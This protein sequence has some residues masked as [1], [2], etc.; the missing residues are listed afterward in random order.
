MTLNERLLRAKRALFDK[1]Y[2]FLNDRQREA[3]F[4]AQGPLLV[5]AGAGSGKTTVLVRR[6]DYLVRYGNAYYSTETPERMLFEPYIEKLESLAQM[7]E[8]SGE[9][10]DSALATFAVN[11]V[12]PYQILA[13]TFT[14]KAAGEIKERLEKAL[15]EQ[16]LDIWAGTFH[17]VCAKLLRMYIDRLGFEKSFTIYDTDDQKRLMTAILKEFEVSD[18]S[19]PPKTVLNEISRA[20]E[21]LLL[22]EDYEATISTHDLRRRTILRLYKEY[23]KRKHIA[24][25]LDFDDLILLTVKL[26]E[27]DTELREKYRDKFRYILV[28]E[29]QDTNKAQFKLTK[30]LCNAENNIMVVGDDDQSIYKFRGATIDNILNFDQIFP[31]TKIIKLEQNYRSSGVIVSAANGVISHNRTRKG[32]T[33]WT[34]NTDGEKITVRECFNQNSEAQYIVN[35]IVE[36]V[37]TGKYTF[38]DFAVLYR[39]NAQSNTLES[40]FAKSG[41]PYRIIGGL[42]FYERKE[43]KDVIAYLCVLANP[44]DHLRLKRIINVPKRGIGDTTVNELEQIALAENKDMLEIALHAAAYPSLS[45]AASKLSQFAETM[46]RLRED[47]H[48]LSIGVFVEK[49]LEKTGYLA[50]LAEQDKI[51]STDRAANVKELVSNAVSYE[52]NTPDA[53]LESFLEEVALVADIDNYDQNAPAAVMMTVHSA[54]GLEFPVVFLAGMEEGVFP[55]SQTIGASDEEMEEER[56]LA[57]VAITRAQKELYILYCQSRMV[58]G[59][60]EFHTVSRFVKEIPAETCRFEGGADY[61][62]EAEEYPNGQKPKT[63]SSDT[64]A[65]NNRQRTQK[66]GKMRTYGGA[67]A[68]VKAH[69]AAEK[70]AKA[71]AVRAHSK[72][73]AVGERITHPIFGSGTVLSVKPLSGDVLYEVMFDSVGTKKVM[74]NYAK[75]TRVS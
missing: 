62:F 44:G 41:I 59:R 63:A 52:N 10:L 50:A 7:P 45:R 27:E 13:I 16:A 11:P 54:K 61:T 48:T 60:T 39:M 18:K 8:L 17:S 57:Y 49:V 12:R 70:R 21:K 20:K 22:P 38:S 5:L 23:E 68:Y 65:D 2:A 67:Y 36:L 58:F 35:R 47:L 37:G 53:T 72:P 25:A 4:T 42:R 71:E 30:L 6:I 3:V 1:S 28:D 51:E 33:L 40:M 73:F 66:D 19:F 15:G 9:L 55:G 24:N 56:R 64:D 34:G 29:Y 14:N 75:M 26:F 74:G 32:K 46:Y 43:I 69:E 31:N